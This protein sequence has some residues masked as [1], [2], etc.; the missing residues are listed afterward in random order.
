[1][2]LLMAFPV[3]TGNARTLILLGLY[4][5]LADARTHLLPASVAQQQHSSEA[6]QQKIYGV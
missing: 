5:F 4:F 1:M 2:A 3:S 6:G